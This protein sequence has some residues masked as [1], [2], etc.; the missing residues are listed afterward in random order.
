MMSSKMNPLSPVNDGI[1]D[2][3]H[4]MLLCHASDTNRSDLLDNVKALLG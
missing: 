3:E 2:T 4:F 1:E